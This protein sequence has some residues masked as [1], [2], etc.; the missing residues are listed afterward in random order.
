MAAVRINLVKSTRTKS[1]NSKINCP[2]E[3]MR[4]YVSR[5]PE[6]I[7]SFKDADGRD[8]L[9]I[10][11]QVCMHLLDP[12]VHESCAAFVGRLVSIVITKTAAVLGS[13]NIHL[14]LRS[15]LSKL[16]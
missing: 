15:V 9:T 11:M 8:G 4:T 5:S 13:D 12:R 6:Q 16:Q 1:T 7:V 14:L 3:C 10:V 2:P